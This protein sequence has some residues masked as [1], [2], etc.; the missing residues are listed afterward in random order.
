M[1]T[2]T[3]YATLS[4]TGGTTDSNTVTGELLET[5]TAAKT[6]VTDT[7]S[8]RDTVTYVISLVNSGATALT[9]LTVTDDL[10]GYSFGDTTVYPLSYVDGS[11][12]Y[13]VN[14]ALQPAPTVTAGPPLTSPGSTSPP[15]ATPC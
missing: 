14:G 9:A 2:F 3:N 13:Y 6:A 8:Q 10:G 1:A 11:L 7:Y 5:L 12:R 4:Y 15:A